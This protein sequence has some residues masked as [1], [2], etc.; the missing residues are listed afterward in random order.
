MNE[1]DRD[2]V[3]YIKICMELGGGVSDFDTQ[4]TITSLLA[5]IDRLQSELETAKADLDELRF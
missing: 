3:D 2:I 5:I 1:T 4:R